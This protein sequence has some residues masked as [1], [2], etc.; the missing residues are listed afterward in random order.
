MMLTMAAKVA[1]ATPFKRP[2]NAQ[3]IPGSGFKSFIFDATGGYKR[4]FW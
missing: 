1:G 2:E 3:F 4:Q